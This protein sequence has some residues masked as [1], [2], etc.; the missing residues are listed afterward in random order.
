MNFVKIGTVNILRNIIFSFQDAFVSIR[1]NKGLSTITIGTIAISMT[2][3]G[4]FFLIFINIQMVATGLR[5]KVGM[6][7]YLKENISDTQLESIK[8]NISSY[9]EIKRLSY[10]SKED[11]LYNFRNRL[12]DKKTILDGLGFNPLPSSFFIELKED[13]RE[14]KSVESVA[15]RL[16]VMEGV[17]EIEYGREWIDRFET[18]M[19]FLKLVMTAVGG[20]LAV[21]LLFIISNTIK[22]SVYSRLDEIE[23]MKLVGATNSF[24]KAPFIIEGIIQGFLGALISLASLIIIYKIIISRISYSVMLTFGLSDISFIHSHVMISMIISGVFL[25]F[26][27]SVLSLGRV[28]RVRT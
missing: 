6:E 8:K 19:M 9:N 26:I 7:I 5:G 1:V 17:E 10:I 11:A 23:I 27:G 18:L 25:G 21:G 3:F 12:K 13:F 22:L 15:R 20:V 4:I 16:T 28:L 14:L 2:L 24:I